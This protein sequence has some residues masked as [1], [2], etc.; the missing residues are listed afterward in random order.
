ML[1]RLQ[2]IKI[3]RLLGNPNLYDK[4]YRTKTLLLLSSHKTYKGKKRGGEGGG[5]LCSKEFPQILGYDTYAL[6]NNI[7]TSF[8]GQYT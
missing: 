8:I 4:V 5:G 7:Y 6:N 1:G 3:L 2:L